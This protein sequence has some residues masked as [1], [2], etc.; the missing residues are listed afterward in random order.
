MEKIR[1]LLADD[2]EIIAQTI[3]NILMKRNDIEVIYIAKD[4]EEEYN[5]IIELQPDLVFTD[6]QMP[7][8][9]GIDVIEKIYNSDIEK[10][11]KFVFATADTDMELYRRAYKSGTILFIRKPIDENRVKDAVEEYLAVIEDEKNPK[12]SEENEI[13]E[14][15]SK[16]SFFKKIIK[17]FKERNK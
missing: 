5:K 15:K 10:K 14:E 11:P 7:K 16:E 2:M 17:N 4:G 8:M 13:K 6:N 1:V 3:Q 12:I 9:N